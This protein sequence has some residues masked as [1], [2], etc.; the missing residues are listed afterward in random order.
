MR[1]RIW[2]LPAPILFATALLSCAARTLK[3][4]D[5][6]RQPWRDSWTNLPG[7]KAGDHDSLHRSFDAVYRDVMFPWVRAGE[8]AE[9]MDQNFQAILQSVGDDAFSEALLREPPKTRS[10]VRVCFSESAVRKSFPKT[11]RILCQAPL[12]K[13]PSD[14]AYEQSW[15]ESGQTPPERE[16][17]RLEKD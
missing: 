9:A 16:L 3:V 10:A 15:I 8:D 13:W 14:I 12:L 1:N 2:A 7:A 17:W 5:P 11:H 6:A 4:H